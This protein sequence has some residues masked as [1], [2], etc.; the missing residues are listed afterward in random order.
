MTAKPKMTKYINPFWVC[1]ETHNG[2]IQLSEEDSR[3]ITDYIRLHLDKLVKS[4]VKKSK[5]QNIS[6]K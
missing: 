1:E 5:P 4:K 2:L 3:G 6:L